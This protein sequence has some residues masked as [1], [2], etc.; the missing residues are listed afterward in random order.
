ME[1]C[2]IDTVPRHVSYVTSDISYCLV[3]DPGTRHLQLQISVLPNSRSW[4]L[5]LPGWPSTS[6]PLLRKHP[7]LLAVYSV[8]QL[9][10]RVLQA[11]QALALKDVSLIRSILLALMLT[12]LALA[13]A[14][15]PLPVH[16]QYRCCRRAKQHANEAIYCHSRHGRQCPLHGRHEPKRRLRQL[17]LDGVLANE[18]LGVQ[19][20]DTATHPRKDHPGQPTTP[21]SAC[22]CLLRAAACR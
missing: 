5:P 21:M 17:C 10:Y 19:Q 1:T 6:A 8:D 11:K 18:R 9:G 22:P 14:N 3:E 4:R 13:G 12:R 15:E 16:G 7:V 20:L 2:G